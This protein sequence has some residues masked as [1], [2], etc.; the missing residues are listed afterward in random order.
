M[1]LFYITV[2][3]GGFFFLIH[4]IYQILCDKNGWNRVRT[5]IIPIIFV[6]RNSEDLFILYVEYVYFSVNEAILKDHILYELGLRG[7]RAVI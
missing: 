6:T 2:D 3:S 7:S 1:L 4:R 5:D